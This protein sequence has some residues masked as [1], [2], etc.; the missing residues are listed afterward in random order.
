[1]LMS[2][3]FLAQ[4]TLFAGDFAPRGWLKCEGQ[5]LQIAEYQALFS[6]I[7][8]TYGGDGR[9]TFDLPTLADV[10]GAIY[11]I[12]T[13]DG[14]IRGDGDANR[15][16]G[17]LGE[18]ILFAGNFDPNGW[19][20][21]KGQLMSINENQKLFSVL[22]DAFGI[23]ETNF[24]LPKLDPPNEHMRYL[25]SI[26]GAYP[27]EGGVDVDMDGT[28]ANMELFAAKAPFKSPTWWLANGQSVPVEGDEAL[29]SIIGN[30]YGGNEHDFNL[31][32]LTDPIDHVN[33][34]I[35]SNGVYPVRP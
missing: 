30:I 18:V 9:T 32:N 25:I 12:N 34:V 5:S 24:N 17:V 10:D 31:P 33:W 13:S 11:C 3:S 7:G 29:Y 35:C 27:Y 26:A 28:L 6:L 19:L 8:T 4:I 16:A 1:M 21:C 20:E 15:P 2:E 23:E 22:Q 14:G